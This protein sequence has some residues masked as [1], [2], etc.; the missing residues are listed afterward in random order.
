MGLCVDQR[1]DQSKQDLNKH[2]MSTLGHRVNR[3]TLT[4]F[5]IFEGLR[6]YFLEA[7][8][9]LWRYVDVNMLNSS[10]VL[11]SLYSGP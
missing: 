5:A 4:F 7:C 10:I 6:Q 2:S 11:I 1:E 8:R 9:F 3:K